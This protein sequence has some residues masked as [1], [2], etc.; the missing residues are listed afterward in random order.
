MPLT[1]NNNQFLQQIPSLQQQPVLFE[2]DNPDISG[3]QNEPYPVHFLPPLIQNAVSEAQRNVQ[4]PVEFVA[5]AALAAISLAC[6]DRIDVRRRVG[7]E[8]PTSLNLVVISESG[9]RKSSVYNIFMDAI[10]KYEEKKDKE[11]ELVIKKFHAEYSRWKD[12]LSGKKSAIKLSSKKNEP[13]DELNKQH[14]EILSREPIEPKVPKLIMNNAT[15]EGIE[16]T[17]HSRW[18]SS[19]LVSDE[20][21]VIFESR[22]L[23]K[24]G[25]LNKL[26]DG[27][28]LHVT[29]KKKE[30]SFVLR[31]VR[32]SFFAMVNSD[33][34]KNFLDKKGELS[35]DNGFLARCLFAYPVSTKGTRFIYNTDL[36]H[37]YVDDFCKRLSDILNSEKPT[38]R[39]MLEFSPE[40]LNAWVNF[41]NNV[42]ADQLKCGL[43]YDISDFAT[44][45]S[46]NVARLAALF[47]YFDGKTGA[48]GVETIKQAIRICAWYMCE[49]KRLFSVP[50]KEF[51]EMADAA[52]LEKFLIG[53]CQRMRG[54]D[55]IEKNRITQGVP[56]P[57]RSNKKRRDDAL[58]AL[59]EAGKVRVVQFPNS[60][61]KF[62]MLYQQWFPLDVDFSGPELLP[63]EARNSSELNEQLV[64]PARPRFNT[65]W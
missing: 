32:F 5:A 43:L 13:L 1:V 37:Q 17:L 65:R 51:C 34:F 29:R 30:D 38:S 8:G 6:Q 62:V 24:L 26:W 28:E 45:I 2:N 16:D 59:E 52:L 22:A 60:K 64:W 31:D 4:A 46:E 18:P 25:D 58:L 20:G 49:F 36:P 44:K 42:E 40:A 56:E 50:D 57:L 23:N 54:K 19:G 39:L 27:K 41:Y 55:C 9:E 7:L 21:G 47:H 63:N 12:E 53:L 15:V 3:T 48:I 33:T 10:H 61:T 35:R 11:L 14:D